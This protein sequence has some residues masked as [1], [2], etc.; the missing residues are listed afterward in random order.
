MF[1]KC[2]GCR[3]TSPPVAAYTGIHR[4]IKCPIF[5]IGSAA[6]NSII[7]RAVPTKQTITPPWINASS[8]TSMGTA[9]C[10]WSW[11]RCKHRTTAVGA[12]SITNAFPTEA[13]QKPSAGCTKPCSPSFGR[14]C[15]VMMKAMATTAKKKIDVNTTCMRYWKKFVSRNPTSKS[16]L[17]DWKATRP[18]RHG[19]RT[20]YMMVSRRPV[21]GTINGISLR[22]CRVA[23]R[24]TKQTDSM[25]NPHSQ[26]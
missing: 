9:H 14:S 2:V 18:I 23:S 6:S 25:V 8:A 1:F 3:R 12:R 21:A 20:V 16:N 11:K 24:R 15:H 13:A 17:R 10:I 19:V 26:V 5:M 4:R 7:R 22:Q